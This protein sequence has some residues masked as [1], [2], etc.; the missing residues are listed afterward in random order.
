MKCLLW[1]GL[2]LVVVLNFVGCG[3]SNS[4]SKAPG[5]QIPVT[6]YLYALNSNHDKISVFKINS[7]GTLGQVS[8]VD[9]NDGPVCAV[10]HPDR[11]H[12][13]V[14]TAGTLDNDYNDY[15]RFMVLMEILAS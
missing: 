4:P 5:P 7:D 9:T 3:K 15:M 2:I 10:V 1:G 13:L 12:L 8:L 6:R 14:C 11:N